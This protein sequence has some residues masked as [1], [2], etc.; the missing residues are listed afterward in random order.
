MA[1][2]FGKQARASG[3]SSDLVELHHVPQTSV[4]GQ[5][6]IAG[7]AAT[8]DP[9]PP[10]PGQPGQLAECEPTHNVAA[11]KAPSQPNL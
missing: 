5:H 4:L 11:A 10:V 8:H 3:S 1:A 2:T 7:Q 9:G 6:G